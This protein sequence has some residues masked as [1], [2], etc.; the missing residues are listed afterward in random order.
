VLDRALPSIGQPSTTLESLILL[1]C[2]QLDLMDRELLL[3]KAQP[4]L[5]GRQIGEEELQESRVAQLGWLMRRPVEPGPQG[6]FACLRDR[7]HAPAPP[8]GLANLVD[9]ADRSEARRLAVQQGVGKRPEVAERCPDVTLELVGSGRPFALEQPEHE[10]RSGS[11][12]EA[13]PIDRIARA[14]RRHVH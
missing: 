14:S 8:T 1:V 5:R 7:E 2:R 9:E 4:R 10:V 6:R 11:Q 3:G 12:S 13:V